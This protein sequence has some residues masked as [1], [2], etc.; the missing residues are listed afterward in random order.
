MVENSSEIASARMSSTTRKSLRRI[1]KNQQDDTGTD[2]KNKF[3]SKISEEDVQLPTVSGFPIII[4][5]DDE[6][7]T[8]ETENCSNKDICNEKEVALGDVNNMVEE[9]KRKSGKHCGKLVRFVP[10]FISRNNIT[11]V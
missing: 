6:K 5:T 9:T 4:V 2:S 1:K 3:L 8:S 10:E 7:A 11:I